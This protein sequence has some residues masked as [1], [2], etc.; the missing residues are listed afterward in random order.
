VDTRSDIYSLGAM[1]Y[2]LLTGSTPLGVEKIQ[3]AGFTEKLRM[4]RDV[5]PARPSAQ[6]SS[7][8]TLPAVARARKTKSPAELAKLVKGDLDWIVM[9]CLEKDRTR[10]YETANG[11]AR[12]I[13][14]YLADEQVEACPP[15]ASYRLRRFARKH[16]KAL[17]A[18]AAF[19]LLLVLGVVVSTWQAVRAARAANRMET[20][21][22]QAQLALAG[23]VAERLEGEVRQMAI[24]GDTLEATL[25]QR[26]DWSEPQMANLLTDLLSRD[27]RIRG[28]TL[29][30]EPKQFAGKED[31]CLYVYRDPEGKPNRYQIEQLLYP[32]GPHGP[33][34]REKHWYKGPLKQGPAW[35]GP[36][37]D[38]GVYTVSYCRPTYRRGNATSVGVLT[39]DLQAEDFKRV[40]GWLEK[41]NLG[42]K[43]Y[44]FVVCGAGATDGAGN[45]MK[46]TFIGHPKYRTPRKITDSDLEDDIDPSFRELTER[47]LLG[48]SGTGKAIDPATGKRSAFLFAPVPSAGWMFVAVIEQAAE[49]P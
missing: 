49:D 31:Y 39:V 5:E 15:S 23:Q 46:G 21:F 24:V 47:I 13:Q 32:D 2:E 37:W 27:P 16:R 28:I 22:D 26:A 19:V 48:K 17:A 36:G 38:V 18:T 40:W 4:I 45:D 43:S 14:H 12:D 3:Q 33:L 30:F 44:G 34:F 11:L 7:S 25:A 35:I 6:L 1:L 8:A 42:K 9:K 41:L 20:A 29:A 10:R